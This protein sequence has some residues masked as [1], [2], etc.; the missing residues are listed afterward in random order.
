[1]TS[2]PAA[3]TIVTPP[4]P[5]PFI[6][7]LR[8]SLRAQAASPANAVGRGAFLS[9]PWRGSACAVASETWASK[10]S[11]YEPLISVGSFGTSRPRIRDEVLALILRSS[12]APTSPLMYGEP[13]SHRLAIDL[14]PD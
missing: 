7:L 2:T 8:P 13:A 9:R 3:P 14:G 5:P 10:I 6:V 12:A 11:R 4:R 1:V